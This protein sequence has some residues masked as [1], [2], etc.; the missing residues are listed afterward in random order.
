MVTQIIRNESA[1]VGTSNVSI[2]SAITVGQRYVLNVKNI[3]T[4]G[5]IITLSWQTQAQA[6]QGVVLNPGDAWSESVDSAFV[7]LN[8][9][10]FAISDAAG[11][12]IAI[13]ERILV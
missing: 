10:V 13:H 2:S 9:E 12:T 7:P 1:T 11:G 5:Q 6:N 3:S 4:G 8:T